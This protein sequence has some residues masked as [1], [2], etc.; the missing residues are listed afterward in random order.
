MN[1]YHIGVFTTCPGKRD[2]S[3]RQHKYDVIYPSESGS[4]AFVVAEVGTETYKVFRNLLGLLAL[5]LAAQFQSADQG[6]H[7]R[8]AG[9]RCR[10]QEH[11][12]E[13][14]HVSKD[15]RCL[16]ITALLAAA[17]YFSQGWLSSGS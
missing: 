12:F 11:P 6:A 14:V 10:Q 5:Q 2:S 17:Q 16:R 7:A 4:G 1:F 8:Y 15:F 9:S 3:H 13:W